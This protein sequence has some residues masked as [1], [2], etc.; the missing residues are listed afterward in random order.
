MSSSVHAC[1]EYDL[2]INNSVEKAVRKPPQVCTPCLPINNRKAFR[3]R[4]QRFNDATNRGKELVAKTRP[5]VFIPSV[6][7]FNV[8]GGGRPKDR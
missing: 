7:I 2:I 3:V 5:L 4:R 1:H 6:G 8:R